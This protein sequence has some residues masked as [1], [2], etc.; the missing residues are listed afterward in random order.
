MLAGASGGNRKTWRIFL[1]AFRFGR[2]NARPFLLFYSCPARPGIFPQQTNRGI[3]RESFSR[4]V[5]CCF[6]SSL[7][8]KTAS[9]SPFANF[10]SGSPRSA[11]LLRS[12]PH[13]PAPLQKA[14]LLD[15]HIRVR[16]RPAGPLKGSAGQSVHSSLSKAKARAYI[17]RRFDGFQTGSRRTAFQKGKGGSRESPV[18]ALCN[19]LNG[20]L[21]AVRPG[22]PSSRLDIGAGE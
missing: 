7:T 5:C 13:K 2:N 18:A 3:Q 10:R 14:V 1:P 9:E 22:Q 11:R 8:H 17:G 12:P 21:L 4:G 16:S 19:A 6:N 20:Y 15:F